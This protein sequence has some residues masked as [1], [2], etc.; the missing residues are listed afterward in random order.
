M[1]SVVYSIILLFLFP[2]FGLSQEPPTVELESYE[3]FHC[4]DLEILD[5][6]YNFFIDYKV[7]FHGIPPYDAK[8]ELTDPENN[9]SFGRRHEI[10]NLTSSSIFIG[11]LPFPSAHAP[12]TR[13]LELRVVEFKDGS[14]QQSDPFLTTG[15]SGVIIYNIYEI[16][17][18]EFADIEITRCGESV[19]I[20]AI[21]GEFGDTFSWSVENGT[22]NFSPDNEPVTTFTAV[23]SDDF[24]KIIFT[25]TNVECSTDTS[26]YVKLLGSPKAQIST[27][28]EVCG[29]GEATVLF[30]FSDTFVPHF[31]FIVKYKVGTIQEETEM[32]SLF[33]TRTH[34][35]KGETVFALDDVIDS[36]NCDLPEDM[37]GIAIV[38][39]IKPIADAGKDDEICGNSIPLAAN[40]PGVGESGKWSSNF[41]NFEKLGE[42]ASHFYN[43]NFVT[44]NE[45]N[46]Y[47]TFKLVWT[48]SVNDKNCSNADSIYVTLWEMPD[49]NAGNDTTIYGNEIV[50][51]AEKP[52]LPKATGAWK[53]IAGNC[54]LDDYKIHNARAVGFTVNNPAKLEWTVTNGLCVN[55]DIVTVTR[56]PIR[57]LTAFS[58]NNDGKNDVFKILGAEEINNNTLIIFD[59]NGIVVFKKNNYGKDGIYWDG[60]SNGKQVPDGIYHYIFSGDGIKPEKKFLVIKRN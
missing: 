19:E 41:G 43:P 44:K 3:A 9:I 35:V 6:T 16:P 51:F 24:Y 47:G 29:S 56:L 55:S 12:N 42:D 46:Q 32:S 4:L 7:T 5:D 38:K 48:V 57:Y 36:N 10:K 2:K 13:K 22:D 33:E 54:I 28:S 11:S 31:P 30:D 27:D 17:K 15:I 34:Y 20:S 18:P 8:I 25:Q 14:V 60:T 53:V 37:K 40:P 49:V 39:N 23:P 50:L 21:P 26:I 1:K 58:P 45:D 59:K 52:I